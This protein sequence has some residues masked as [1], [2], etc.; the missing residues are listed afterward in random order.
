MVTPYLGLHLVHSLEV[1]PWHLSGQY[2][3]S[4]F[5]PFLHAGA[6]GR[7]VGCI[8]FLLLHHHRPSLH[9]RTVGT[10][11]KVATKS[12]NLMLRILAYAVLP[13]RVE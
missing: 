10:E 3:D 6:T 8:I 2:D 13:M 4:G 7:R 12:T 9:T 5:Y 11:M 1:Y